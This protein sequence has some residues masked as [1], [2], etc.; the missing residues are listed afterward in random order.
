MHSFVCASE[1]EVAETARELSRFYCTFGAWFKNERP[2]NQGFLEPLSEAE[3]AAMPQYAPELMRRNL[4]IGEPEA[5]IARLKA[6]EALGYDQYSL[7]ID[8]GLSFA[9]KKRS[10]QLFID[11]VM[12]AFN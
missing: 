4:V 11:K 12:P 8:S 2:I 6:Y 7:W 9:R 3:M 10:L 1:A 5:V